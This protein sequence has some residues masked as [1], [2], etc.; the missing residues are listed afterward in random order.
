MRSLII[1]RRERARSLDTLYTGVAGLLGDVD[2]VKFTKEQVRDLAKTLAAMDFTA[3]DRVLFDI[4]LRRAAHAFEQIRRLPGLIYYEEDAYQEFMDS[5]KFHGRFLRFFQSLG[6]APVIVTGYNVMNYLRQRGINAHCIPKAY[7]DVQLH[8]MG[9]S[10]DLEVAFIGRIKSLVYGERR[11]ILESMQQIVGLQLLR[12]ESEDEYLNVLNRIRI[13]FSADIGFNEYM[14][15]N[16]EA[17]ACGC[18][19]LAKRQP[20]E[21]ERLG[22]IDM[23]NVVHYDTLDEAVVRCRELLADPAK[24]ERIAQAGRELAETRHR[25]SARCEEFAALITAA[26]P[27]RSL[28]SAS[29]WQRIR[30]GLGL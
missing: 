27:S 12:T 24:L 7:D 13:F 25:L 20:S 16:F 9:G 4:P 3:Y 26:Y 15:K 23:H 6:G 14:A 21:D 2:I 19:L 11:S 5:S 18:L 10:R 30:M 22:F 17:M 1:N 29:W 28:A 8:D